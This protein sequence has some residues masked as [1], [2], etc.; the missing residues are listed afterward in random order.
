MSPARHRVGR[1]VVGGVEE[2]VTQC[3]KQGITIRVGAGGFAACYF[4]H[5]R[6]TTWIVRLWRVLPLESRLSFN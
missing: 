4:W 2:T 1:E 3:K 6:S 5:R